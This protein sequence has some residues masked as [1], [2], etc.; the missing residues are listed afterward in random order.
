[1]W[2]K[3]G[4][5]TV[6]FRTLRARKC[7]EWWGTLYTDFVNSGVRGFW[8]DMNEPA[9]FER[10]DKTMPL[11]TVH[12]V[13]GRKTDHREIHNVF[14]MQNARA[15]YEGMLQ[16]RPD[17]RPFV[18][19]RAAYAGTERYA[20]TWTGDNSSTWNHMRLSIPQLI[21]LGLSGYR[22]CRR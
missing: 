17:L 6:F 22:F 13:E 16:L 1:M 12:R 19:T 7:V 11:D 5:G 20:A 9:I 8:N 3:S 21:N 2:A 18:L 14:G 10:A 15:T 4:P